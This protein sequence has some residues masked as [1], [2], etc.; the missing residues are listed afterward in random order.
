MISK[1][2]FLKYSYSHSVYYE[3]ETKVCKEISS[4]SADYSRKKRRVMITCS[5]L[6]YSLLILICFAITRDTNCTIIFAKIVFEILTSITLIY[7]FVEKI[8]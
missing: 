3:E 2:D 1:K 5:A 4:G 6:I 8:S 7:F